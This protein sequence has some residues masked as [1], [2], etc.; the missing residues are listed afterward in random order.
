MYLVSLYPMD[1]TLDDVRISNEHFHTIL[2]TMKKFF[3][4]ESKIVKLIRTYVMTSHHM[5]IW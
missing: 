3:E 1:R 2:F 4:V 5:L